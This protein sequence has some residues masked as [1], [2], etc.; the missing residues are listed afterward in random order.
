MT[1]DFGAQG[2]IV[3]EDVTDYDGTTA[4]VRSHTCQPGT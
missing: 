2:L 1:H 3:S 4:V